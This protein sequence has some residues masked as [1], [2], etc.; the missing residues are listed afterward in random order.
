MPILRAAAPTYRQS[1]LDALRGVAAQRPLLTTAGLLLLW[2]LLIRLPFLHVIHDDEAFYAVVAQRWLHGEL[3][4]VAS[5]DVK[6]PGVFAVLAAFQALFG[7]HLLVIKAVEIAFTA[8]GA[9]ALYRLLQPVAGPV[10]AGIAVG[11]YPLYSLF[12]LGVAAPCQLIEAAFTIEAFALA[13][14]ADRAGRRRLILMALSGLMMG[15]AVMTKQT[16]AFTALGLF[17]WAAWRSR[18][19]RDLLP[20]AAFCAAGLLPALGFSVCF[21]VCGHFRDAF[22]AVVVNALSRSQTNMSRPSPLGV[23]QR[24]AQF[25]AFLKPILVISVGTLLALLRLPRL[26]AAVGGASL[27]LLLIWSLSEALGILACRSPDIWYGFVLIPPFLALAAI[28][29]CHGVAFR[30]D[31]RAAWIAAYLLAAAAQPF[32]VEGGALFLS[33]PFHAPDYTGNVR[34]A[35]ALRAAGLKPGGNLLATGRGQYV[36]LMTGALPKAR[37]FN[38]MHLMCAFPTPDPDPLVAAFASR[39]DFVLVSNPSL[40][41]GCQLPARAAEL[42]N[43]LAAHYV[44]IGHARGDW[45]SFTIYRRK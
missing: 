39:P 13:L 14:A 4:Y 23:L 33:G 27:A 6:A 12:M 1:A 43:E 44:A 35:A 11:A 22:D 31:Q 36:Y 15:C 20:L 32:L 7:A 8:W 29:L 25:P 30:P 37:Y 5:Y 19:R 24:V 3:P 28:V 42:Q 21:L 40:Y 38:A 16:A 34:S 17:G 2:T 26:R 10:C 41:M 45:D 18:A 9:L